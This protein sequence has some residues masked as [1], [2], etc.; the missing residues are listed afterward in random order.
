[1][2]APCRGQIVKFRNRKNSRAEYMRLTIDARTWVSKDG[3][4]FVSV[5]GY[6]T[7]ADGQPTHVREVAHVLFADEVEIITR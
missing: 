4:S 7:R 3:V 5:Y 2:T 1:V 6:R